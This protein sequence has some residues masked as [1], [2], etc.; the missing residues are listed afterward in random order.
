MELLSWIIFG[1]FAGLVAKMLMPGRDPSG[2]II[3]VVLG[4]VGAVLGG[5]VAKVLNIG[6]GW[7]TSFFLAVIGAM[8]LLGIYRLVRG[9]AT[10]G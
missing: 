3:T 5:E 1:F 4:I 10:V 2:F 6:G 9:N 7:W 8:I